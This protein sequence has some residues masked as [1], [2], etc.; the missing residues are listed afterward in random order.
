MMEQILMHVEHLH[1]T[2]LTDV[3]VIRD[4][5]SHHLSPLRHCIH[6][7]CFYSG[8]NDVTYSFIEGKHHPEL[9]ATSS[10]FCVCV[11]VTPTGS[12][13]VGSCSG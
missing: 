4:F 10:L 13:Y 9:L 7:A 1:S 11:C 12:D 6:L 2:G 3:M 8:P 5:L